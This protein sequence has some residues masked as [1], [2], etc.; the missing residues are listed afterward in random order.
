[1]KKRLLDVDTLIAR[2][3]EVGILGE[4]FDA[5]ERE[6]NVIEMIE[7]LVEGS[8]IGHEK[9]IPQYVDL[10]Y[11]HYQDRNSEGPRKKFDLFDVV[12]VCDMGP[13]K[14]LEVIDF[15]TYLDGGKEIEVAQVRSL[16]TKKVYEYKI[17]DLYT[18]PRLFPESIVMV[19][20]NHYK[21]VME[22]TW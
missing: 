14:A 2:I 19:G 12:Y 11:S 4:G 15:L 16:D 18:S 7:G 20:S 17:E 5:S 21:D 6:N 8:T 10:T 9:V 3:R 1:M 22:G 13:S